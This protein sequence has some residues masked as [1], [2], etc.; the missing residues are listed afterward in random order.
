[1]VDRKPFLHDLPCIDK[2]NFR[3]YHDPEYAANREP[4]RFEIQHKSPNYPLNVRE[5]QPPEKIY[6]QPKPQ[7]LLKYLSRRGPQ[8]ESAQSGSSRIQTAKRKKMSSCN[9][10]SSQNH[11]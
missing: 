8:Y 10:D 6:N 5:V 3:I 4:R 11:S 2:N 7:I 9:R 1:M